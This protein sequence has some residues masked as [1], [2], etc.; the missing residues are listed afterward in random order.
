[1]HLTLLFCLENYLTGPI[2]KGYQQVRRLSCSRLGFP[3][4]TKNSI[5]SLVDVKWKLGLSGIDGTRDAS[6]SHGQS[7]FFD[8]VSRG[9][10]NISIAV[11]VVD[12]CPIGQ[13]CRY[14]ALPVALAC[15]TRLCCPFRRG[16][17]RGV[18][19]CLLGGLVEIIACLFGRDEIG[20]ELQYQF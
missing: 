4:N 14:R 17:D 13:R 5:P 12:C 20:H 1:M 3:W 16:D 15:H 11:V 2:E 19:R 9:I 10:N 6:G 7:V 8:A 18:P